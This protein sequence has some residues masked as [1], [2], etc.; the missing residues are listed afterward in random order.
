M[1]AGHQN[2]ICNKRPR[3]NALDSPDKR[4]HTTHDGASHGH[5]PMLGLSTSQI[6]ST[7]SPSVASVTSE[8][9]LS[10]M[11]CSCTECPKFGTGAPQWDETPNEEFFED[12]HQDAFA[13]DPIDTTLP[14]STSWTEFG[15]RDFEDGLTADAI[16]QDSSSSAQNWASSNTCK[17]SRLNL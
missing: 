17:R 14:I 7:I 9:N 11:Q 15:T 16:Q 10:S 8:R 2:Q 6:T 13:T 4:R 12:Q 5:E 1:I 3:L